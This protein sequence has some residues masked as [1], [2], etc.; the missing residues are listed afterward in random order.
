[1]GLWGGAGRLCLRYT[2]A[3]AC[4]WDAVS[5]LHPTHSWTVPCLAELPTPFGW[6]HPTRLGHTMVQCIRYVLC[7]SN[8]QRRHFATLRLPRLPNMLFLVKDVEVPHPTSVCLHT[9]P[10]AC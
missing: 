8:I 4:C 10:Q 9:L 1:M 2:Y 6:V 7:D 3:P 5:V